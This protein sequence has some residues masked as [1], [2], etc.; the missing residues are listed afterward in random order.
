M[1][2]RKIAEIETM[3]LGAGMMGSHYC[4]EAQFRLYQQIENLEQQGFTHIRIGSAV[5]KIATALRRAM[6]G[7]GG[8]CGFERRIAQA[9]P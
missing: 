6:F 5:S 8:V 9:T 2:K 7:S 3:P 1:T 4:H